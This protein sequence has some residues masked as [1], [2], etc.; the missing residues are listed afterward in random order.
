MIRS[1]IKGEA[2]EDKVYVVPTER[3]YGKSRNDRTKSWKDVYGKCRC[4]ICRQL[5]VPGDRYVAKTVKARGHWE[6]QVTHAND[7]PC[8]APKKRGRKQ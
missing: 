5:L 4:S 7:V 2:K 8:E 1:K 3:A 6:V